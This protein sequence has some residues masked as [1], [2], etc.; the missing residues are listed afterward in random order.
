MHTY[1]D[2]VV[3]ATKSNDSYKELAL[4]ILDSL[5]TL[6]LVSEF[7][8]S[9]EIKEFRSIVIS[10]IDDFLFDDLDLFESLK[11]REGNLHDLYSPQIRSVIVDLE[12]FALQDGSFSG[13]VKSIQ[14]E[15]KK[16]SSDLG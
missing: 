3:F 7:C 9:S 2:L 1:A 4:K 15:I 10:L 13:S 8:V 12:N 11:K 6:V 5:S 16:I 14:M